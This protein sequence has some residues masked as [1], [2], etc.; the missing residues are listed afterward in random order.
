MDHRLVERRRRVAE[1]RARSNL[2]RLLRMLVVLA[3]VAVL[4][5]YVQS[6][7]M[8]VDS[9]VVRGADRVD[10]RSVLTDNGIIEGRPLVVLDVYGAEK[11]LLGDPWVAQ[12]TVARDWPTGIVVE[13]EERTPSANLQLADGWWLVAAD[14]TLLEEAE[15]RS[16]DLPTGL[17]PQLSSGDATGNLE[18]EGAVEYLA[19]LPERY[20]TDAEITVQDEGLVALV[21]GY[22]VRVGRPFDTGEK[23]AV[24]AA[25]I[26]SGV[27][28]G[29]ILTVVAPASPAVLPPGADTS[30]PTTDPG[31]EG[32]AS[33]G[34]DL[35][36]D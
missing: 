36:S 6:P 26:D 18:V 15:G 21:G 32:E 30:T 22:Q 27:E 23:A 31:S 11:A 3:V 17:L 5:W 19:A 4:V 34:Q 12:A 33:E 2:N 9:I 14:G 28:E 8:S 35:G 7:F 1:D 29:S 24:T 20:R 10:V 13:V 16:A 25:M